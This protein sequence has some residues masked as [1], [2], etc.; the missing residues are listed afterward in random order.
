MMRYGPLF[1]GAY[2]QTPD[3][4]MTPNEPMWVWSVVL[5][6]VEVIFFEAI[7]RL[8]MQNDD[9]ELKKVR[10]FIHIQKIYQRESED[11]WKLLSAEVFTLH[12]LDRETEYASIKMMDPPYMSEIRRVP[13]LAAE[14][15]SVTE[16]SYNLIQDIVEREARDLYNELFGSTEE[17]GNAEN[18][19]GG[20]H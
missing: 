4:G 1:N 2:Q 19:E 3:G 16:P 13:W 12:R 17:T 8:K 11:P 14:L 9:Y 6:G 18:A 10:L 15:F 5:K 20:S 7:R